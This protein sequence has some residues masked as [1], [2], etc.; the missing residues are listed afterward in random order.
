MAKHVLI[1]R[2]RRRGHQLCL[3]P[4]FNRQRPRS[5]AF[6]S[7]ANCATIRQYPHGGSLATSAEPMQRE[8]R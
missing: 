1:V 8:A 6:T 4:L 2:V 7:R 3:R 5:E